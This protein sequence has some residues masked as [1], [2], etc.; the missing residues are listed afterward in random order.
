MSSTITAANFL[1][2][3]FN[4]TESSADGQD[5]KTIQTQTTLPDAQTTSEDYVVKSGD[6]LSRIA[7]KR[8]ISQTKIL[9]DNPQI[10]NPN[11]I[12]AGRHIKLA[13]GIGKTI[14]Y[15]VKD[16]DT[17]SKIA[18][19][20]HTTIGDILRANQGK[21][22]K[23]D[24]IFPNQKLNLP[25]GNQKDVPIQKPVTTNS[26]IGAK[27][28]NK[29]TPITDKPVE[30]PTTQTSATKNE[31]SIGRVNIDEFLS[32]DKG[33]SAI[34][35]IVIGNAEGNRYQDGKPTPHY[36][37]HPDP[38]DGLWNI[39]SFSRANDRFKNE[40]KARTPEEA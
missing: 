12:Y 15:T 13:I 14:P 19:E 29:K 11:Q 8:G 2:T 7:E 21:I 32:P 38:G 27:P 10:K 35:A 31:L 22:A 39:G 28:N 1:E 25:V 33:S 37:G 18:K 3:L 17:L 6:T 9:Q 16:G 34:G 23:Q 24:L 40:P 30:T 4:S 5:A 26:P 20:H 36:Y